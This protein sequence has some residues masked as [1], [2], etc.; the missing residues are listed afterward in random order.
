MRDEIFAAVNC[1]G[2]LAAIPMAQGGLTRLAVARLESGGVPVTPLLRRVG[3]S[4]G[5]IADLETRLS[6]RSQ[7]DFL[8][9]AAIALQDDCLGFTLA[10]NHDPREIGMLYYVMASSRTLGDGLKRVA[11]YSQITNEALVVHHRERDGLII[12][13]SY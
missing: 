4:P 9:E 8:D 10:R 7:I 1:G 13:L 12:R 6:V 2:D 5:V 3:L 11:R